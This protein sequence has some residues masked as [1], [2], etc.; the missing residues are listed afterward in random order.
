[1][2]RPAVLE[3]LLSA[4]YS[5]YMRTTGEFFADQE[6]RLM[7]QTH[8]D[9]RSPTS[10]GE[11]CR[12][13]SSRFRTRFTL[14]AVLPC[15]IL[16]V[17]A[18]CVGAAAAS[19]GTGGESSWVTSTPPAHGS[20]AS[21]NWNLPYE[22]PGLDPIHSINFAETEVLANLCDTLVKMNPNFTYSPDLATYSNPNPT[23]WIYNIRSGVKFWDGQPLTPADIIYSLNR[24]R[25]PKLG[26][27]FSYLFSNVKSITQTGPLRVT[28]TLKQPDELFNQA[29]ALS[30]GAI[31]EKQ[32][33]LAKGKQMGTPNVGVM[34]TGPYKFVNWTPGT[35]L[36]ITSNPDYW[37]GSLKPKAGKIIFSFIATDE[38]Q[39]N[40]LTSG[41]V[42]GMYET[43]VS[44]TATLQK[45]KGHL[46]LGASLTQFVIEPI[47]S[48]IRPHSPIENVFVRQALSAAIDRQLVAKNIFNNA[49]AVPISRL[50]FAEPVYPY[51][52][53]VFQN[54]KSSLPSLA[55]PSLSRAKALV[56]KAGHPKAPI[57]LA[58]RS[59]GPAYNSQFAQY[60]KGVASQIGLNIKLDP[61]PTSTFNTVG[62]NTKLDNSI[63]AIITYWFNQLPDPVQWY[64]LFS[65]GPL[66]HT[67]YNIFNGGHYQ[68]AIVGRALTLARRTSDPVKRAQ[69]VVSAEKQLMNDLPWIPVVDMANTLYM[70]SGVSGPPAAQVQQWEPWG[71][72]LGSTG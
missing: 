48:A 68:N 23:T 16:L 66:T 20:L 58:Y 1:M 65:Y 64:T 72:V 37:N 67:P 10:L 49:A 50:L 56:G 5:S 44:G 7:S 60:V 54:A 71:A 28:V 26:S 57:I 2:R 8:S 36:T 14:H 63:D 69:Y 42:Q 13:I 52:N 61:L 25:D 35:S 21:V 29:L 59:D 41:Q 38:A 24:N 45:S 31:T 3:N 47:L 33:D 9:G 18:A 34:C 53:S 11:R 27:F 19:T 4:N 32:F 15:V 51:A 55:A 12:V 17:L 22:P 40:S 6:E 43:P 62:F 46:Y 70:A 30:A 39:V